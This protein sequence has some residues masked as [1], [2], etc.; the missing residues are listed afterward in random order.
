MSR[1]SVR[2]VIA[3]GGNLADP[4]AAFRTAIS[5]LERGSF[6]VERVSTVITT[7]PVGCE[8]GAPPFR[9]GVLT[10]FWSGSPHDLL[11]LCRRLEE[12][13][14]RPADHPKGV[15]R[16]LDLDIILFGTERIDTPDLVV[17]HPRA[18][19]RDFVLIPMREIAP[20]LLALL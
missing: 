14:G 8:E 12:A 17:P 15:S 1:P 19:Q 5:A 7:A 11:A 4:D 20:E 18:K 9:N 13:A 3:F 6:R 2:C 16:T 10:G